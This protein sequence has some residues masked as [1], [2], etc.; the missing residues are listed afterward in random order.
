M[1]L[2]RITQVCA[3]MWNGGEVGEHSENGQGPEFKLLSLR[4]TWIFATLSCCL[5]TAH[6]LRYQRM[7]EQKKQTLKMLFHLSMAYCLHGKL[8]SQKMMAARVRKMGYQRCVVERFLTRKALKILGN[9]PRSGTREHGE[10][11]WHWWKCC[12]IFKARFR[13]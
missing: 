9:G 1:G 10:K 13:P 5:E 11:V 3:L 8:D 2:P 6:K 7:W 4:W 12:Q